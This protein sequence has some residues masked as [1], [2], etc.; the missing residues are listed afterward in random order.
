[1]RKTL[2]QLPGPRQVAHLARLRAADPAPDDALIDDTSLT[3]LTTD[4]LARLFDCGAPLL[5][6]RTGL[7]A[8]RLEAFIHER[9]L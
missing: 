5:V 9:G 3:S 8:R 1:M 4:Q 6:Q 7:F 2:E